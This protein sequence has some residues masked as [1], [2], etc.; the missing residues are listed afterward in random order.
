ME[1]LQVERWLGEDSTPAVH[2]LRNPTFRFTAIFQELDETGELKGFREASFDLAPASR[3]RLNRIFY[4]KLR[5]DSNY[6]ILSPESYRQ[7]T[8]PLLDRTT[9]SP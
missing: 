7:L 3:S 2:A 9:L 6:F 4:G 5:G 1:V 8:T